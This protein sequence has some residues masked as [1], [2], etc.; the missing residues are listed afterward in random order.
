MIN[1]NGEMNIDKEKLYAI[2]DYLVE[3]IFRNPNVMFSDQVRGLEADT[4]D[5]PT[6][7]AGLYEYLNILVEGEPYA[8]MFHWANKIGSWVEEGDFDIMINERMKGYE[9]AKEESNQ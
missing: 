6:V 8:Y 2:R 7:I 3:E 9:R 5:L 4:P 1:H